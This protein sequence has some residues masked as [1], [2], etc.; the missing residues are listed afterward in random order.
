MT[1]N[2]SALTKK[3]KLGEVVLLGIP[4]ECWMIIA[5]FGGLIELLSLCLARKEF[6]KFLW[7]C[8]EIS[9]NGVRTSIEFNCQNVKI[10]TGEKVFLSIYESFDQK[11]L[12]RLLT[13][14][15]RAE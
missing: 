10:H 12:S 4:L 1:Q 11:S 7:W 15:S 5:S 9:E 3:R 6:Y 2:S 13:E 8:Y 14:S